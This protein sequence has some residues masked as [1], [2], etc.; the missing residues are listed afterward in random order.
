M[1][2]RTIRAAFAAL[3]IAAAAPLFAAAPSAR[4][5]VIDEALTQLQNQYVF[6]D[7][8]G[9]I[10]Q[11]VRKHQAAGEYAAAAEDKQFAALLTAHLQETSHDKHMALRYQPNARAKRPA[12]FTSTA[13][14]RDEE[15]RENYG[16]RKLEVLA[17]NVGYLDITGFH[18]DAQI[19]GDTIIGAMA[20]LANTDAMII[21][22][23]ANRGGGEA[24]Q[25]LASYFVDGPVELM[26]LRYRNGT[27][28][29]N[30]TQAHV[31]GR[32]YLDKPLYILTSGK[33]FSAGEAFSYA[34]HSLKR[35][36]LVGTTTRGGGNPNTLIPVGNDYILSIPIGQSVSPVTG[37]SWDG[38]GVAPDVAV[39][40]KAALGVA[41]RRAL[42]ELRER[43]KD[44]ALRASL[45]KDL[46][47]LDKT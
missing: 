5:A 13:A 22:L 35:A 23:R 30:M 46:E 41:H 8:F 17:G 4:D 1:Q 39:D 14:Q 2:L 29:H 34:L 37:G 32:R 15:R 6:P 47:A 43:S 3:V 42:T 18:D 26:E 44:E 10:E 16:L 21:D 38:V 45:A 27:V 24:M 7:K 28:L 9:A 36:T 19:S 40:E 20:F 33:T 31:P 12:A 25:L 11:N